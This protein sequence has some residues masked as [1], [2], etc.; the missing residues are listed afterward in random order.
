MQG[1]L[2][3][4]HKIALT[5]VDNKAASL[6][7]NESTGSAKLGPQI[8]TLDWL[9]QCNRVTV[10]ETSGCLKQDGNALT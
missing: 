5:A 8:V 7:T 10:D 1:A 3:T 4:N 2:Q 6:N 9:A